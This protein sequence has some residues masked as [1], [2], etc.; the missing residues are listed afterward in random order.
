MPRRRL[1]PEQSLTER[2]QKIAAAGLKPFGPAPDVSSAE[3]EGLGTLSERVE[4]ILALLGRAQ[5]KKPGEMICFV[6]YDIE[7]NRVRQQIAKYLLRKGC[8]RVQKS[9]YLA[10]L[11]RKTYQEIADALGEIQA[12]YDNQDSI[13]LVPISEQE[14]YKMRVIGQQISLDVITGGPNTLFI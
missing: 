11:E 14:L 8:V 13:M 12:M 3:P 9:V 10:Q 4:I 5:R 2:L 1:S 7:D 6:M